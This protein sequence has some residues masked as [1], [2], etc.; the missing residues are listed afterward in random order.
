MATEH[1]EATNASSFKGFFYLG[2]ALYK[3]CEYES[4]LRAFTRAEFINPDDA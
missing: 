1:L 4:A 2:I 3:M